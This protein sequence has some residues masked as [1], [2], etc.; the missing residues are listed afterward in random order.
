MDKKSKFF[1][2]AVCKVPEVKTLFGTG[3]EMK[4]LK[5]RDVAYIIV[6]IDLSICVGFIVAISLLIRWTR[7]DLRLAD[8]KYIQ[9]TD[10]SVMIKNMPELD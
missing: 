10:F 3:K 1:V 4:I 9:L 6:I 8:A 2:K 5:R 7:K